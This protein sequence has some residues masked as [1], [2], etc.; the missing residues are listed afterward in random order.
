MQYATTA[1]GVRIAF[2]TAGNGPTLLRVP[3]LPFSHTQREWENGSPF[4]E[5]L[6][7]HWTVVQFDPRGTGLSDR[8]VED[9][10]L[11]A[12]M[13]DIDAVLD[14][15]N[16]SRVPLHGISWSG[17]LAVTY[18]VRHPERV[19]HLILDDS[20][21]R[22]EDFMNIPQIRALDQLTG[23]WDTFLEYLTYM[24]YGLGREDAAPIVEF[25]KSCVTAEGA[26]RI[27]D[28]A[29]GDDVTELL[30]Q[31][32]QPALVIQHRAASM[33]A[34][35]SAREMAALIPDAR[36]VILEGQA[37]DDTARIVHAIA[38]FL[39]TEHDDHH[40]PAA[41]P[42]QMSGVRA[43]LFTDMVGHTEMM[44]R[45]GD[46]AGRDVLREHEDLIR[47]V[48]RDH[49]GEEIKTMGD[50]FMASFGSVNGAVECAIHLQRAFARRNDS[51]AEP[52]VIRVGLTAGEP[53]EDGGDLF[54]A[55]VIMA[56]RIA[57]RAGPGEILASDVIRGLCAGKGFLFADRGE[58][59]LRGFEDRVH[60]YEV[61]WQE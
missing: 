34:E 33:N 41:A 61:G 54:G 19:S 10:S 60:L 40:A 32:T 30:P 18:A 15:L 55:T 26:Q 14:K 47:G 59:E 17:P 53:I 57:M 27:F 36:L 6:A 50:G 42:A 13:L 9:C 45:L 22:T 28:T 4:Y 12:R 44:D 7:S 38:D 35:A 20:H 5:E 25:M 39:E 46:A 48:L 31:V 3:S 37:A 58:S 29:R 52:V 43:I 49:Q 21:A 2:G 1:D 51:S 11:E 24:I 8:E 23:E 56:S 16:L